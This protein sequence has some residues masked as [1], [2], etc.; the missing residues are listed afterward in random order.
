MTVS[1]LPDW[2]E[3]QP[4]TGWLPS[5][6]LGDFWTSRELAYFFF[7]RDLKST[8]KQT[9]LGVTWVLLGPLIGARQLHVPVQRPGRHRHRGLLL[10]PGH[11][12]LR[13]LDLHQRHD[14]RVCRE[15]ARARGPHHPRVVPHD[16]GPGLGRARFALV[17]LVVG[18]LVAIGWA[19]LTWSFPSIVGVAGR[20]PPRPGADDPDR[21]RTRPVLRPGPGQVPRLRRL[22]RDPAPGHVLPRLGRLPARADRRPLPESLLYLN[23]VTGAVTLF[24]WALTPSTTPE[25][26]GRSPCRSVSP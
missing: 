12:R 23:P 7:V 15:P 10:R 20:P 6:R 21:P 22:P 13:R 2:T 9:L 19:V 1:E 17:N 14:G 11:Q 16:R 25:V 3:N 24:R 8:Y 26:R 4:R 5:L 18:S